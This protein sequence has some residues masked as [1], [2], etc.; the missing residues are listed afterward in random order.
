ML[1]CI[2]VMVFLLFFVLI[3]KIRHYLFYL[4]MPFCVPFLTG[5]FF[6]LYLYYHT[7]FT[8]TFFAAYPFFLLKLSKQD[9][10][11]ELLKIWGNHICSLGNGEKIIV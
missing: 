7:F 1:R 6:Y 5:T 10:C 8:C 9:Q 2:F 11:M 4:S 3:K